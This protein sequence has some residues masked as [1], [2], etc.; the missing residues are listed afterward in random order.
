MKRR[1][2]HVLHRFAVGGLENGV[3]NIVNG[4]KDESLEHIIVCM[5][6]ADPVFRKRIRNAHVSIIELNKKPGK[7]LSCYWQMF[8]L[9]RRWKPDVVHTRNLSALEMQLP[10]FLARV[11]LRVHSEHGRDQDDAKGDNKKNQRLRRLFMPLVH[12]VVALSEEIKRYLID[13]VGIDASKVETLCNGVD[14]QRFVPEQHKS[15]D[16]A[17]RLHAIYV[18][19]LAEVKNPLLILRA[20][21]VLR[22]RCPDAQLR[23]SVVGDGPLMTVCQQYVLGHNLANQVHFV[24]ASEAVEQLFRQADVF[25]LGSRTEGISNTIL[26]A[27]ACGLPVV[28]TDVGGNQELVVEG[29]T[30]YLVQDNEEHAM[31]DKLQLYLEDAQLRAQHSEKARQRALSQFSLAGMLS[32]YQQIYMEQTVYM[33]GMA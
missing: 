4:L 13:K 1:V 15:G 21:R 17:H 2:M 32:R 18:G 5:T 6:D 22:D 28:A 27:M 11:P 30:G 19:R 33:E 7:N 24:G 8:K 12:H 3:V 26:E 23:L 31:A 14:C 29:Q 20:L 10:A 9:I 25:V 16:Q